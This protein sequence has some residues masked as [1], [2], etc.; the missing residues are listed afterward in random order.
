VRNQCIIRHLRTLTQRLELGKGV[1]ELWNGGGGGPREQVPGGIAGE[2]FRTHGEGARVANQGGTGF[3][4]ERVAR[5][6]GVRS[7]REQDLRAGI[8]RDTG[9]D[10]VGLD[11]HI[12]CN[13]GVV[14]G[15]EAIDPEAS[16]GGE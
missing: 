1:V 4:R 8:E 7:G 14:P 5:D 2:R 9:A 16:M 13:C 3:D 6:A 10:F 15:A 12:F 11:Q